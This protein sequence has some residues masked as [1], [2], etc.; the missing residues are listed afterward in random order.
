MAKLPKLDGLDPLTQA[1]LSNNALTDRQNRH[2]TLLHELTSKGH[3]ISTT[4]LWEALGSAKVTKRQLQRDL[5]AMAETYELECSYQG[6]AKLWRPKPGSSPRYVLPVLDEN[7]ALA[8]LLAERLL[9]Q[10]LP[11]NL[12]GALAPWLAESRRL[13]AQKNPGN[14][15]HQR[16]T[17]KREG[18][19]LEPPEIKN[20]VLRAVYQ[21]LQQKESLQITYQKA[22]GEPKQKLVLPAGVVASN[23]TLY[24]LSYTDKYKDFTTYAMHRIVEAKRSYIREENQPTIK[25]LQTYVD[26]S[27][28]DIFGD[29]G[30]E[31][32]LTVDF[33][34]QV[35]RKMFE[36][37]L[38]RQQTMTPLPDGW[39]RVKTLVRH[40]GSLESWLL[41]YGNRIRVIA[42]RTLVMQLNRL[43]QPAPRAPRQS[44]EAAKAV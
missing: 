36:Y 16:L 39:L 24:L 2:L 42:P 11:V 17:T 12:L 25:A 31:V 26:E 29:E 27:F 7:A 44:K 38:G 1:R 18:V 41:A 22:E 19:H 30:E 20:D 8:F 9:K 3:P 10:M 21:A 40:T 28:N 37:K 13:L 35:Q 14:P 4:Q 34:E 43:R 33:N 5:E 32:E 23:Q 6:R 15:W